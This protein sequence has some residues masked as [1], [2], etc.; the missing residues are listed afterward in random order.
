[1]SRT[2]QRMRQ[3]ALT[4]ED[5]T[6]DVACEG[7]A[8]ESRSFKARKKA[9]LFLRDVDGVV[10]ARIKLARCLREAQ[11]LAR[12]QP[13]QVQVGKMDWVA[14]EFSDGDPLPWELLQRFVKDA[15][16]VMAGA[17]VT[18]PART[19]GKAKKVTPKKGR[20]RS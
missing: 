13:Q 10:K 5:V 20:R 2:A 8:L 12:S 1:M 4:L 7:T 6:E 16:G 17:A 11:A 3:L 9:F 19:A 15:H 14:L 18:R